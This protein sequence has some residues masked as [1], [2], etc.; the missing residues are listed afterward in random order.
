MIHRPG[1]YKWLSRRAMYDVM[2][3]EARRASR[4]TLIGP[5]YE[6]A[7]REQA[8]ETVLDLLTDSEAV[9][10]GYVSEDTL[11]SHYELVRRGEVVDPYLYQMLTLEMWLRRYWQQCT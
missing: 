6:R 9:L 8:C 10:R 7:I 3:E 4:K 2:P 11:H 1:E 5:L